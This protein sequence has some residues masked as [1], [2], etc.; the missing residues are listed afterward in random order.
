MAVLQIK[1]TK[2]SIDRC[3]KQ[4]VTLTSLGLRKLNQT[5]EKEATPQVLGMIKVVQHLVEVKEL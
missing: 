2:S 1:Q 3:E 4:K 5:V